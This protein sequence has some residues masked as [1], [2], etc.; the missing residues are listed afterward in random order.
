MNASI[1]A[2]AAAPHPSARVDSI[3]P[4]AGVLTFTFLR[5]DGKP[6]DS[7][8]SIA[9][10]APVDPVEVQTEAGVEITYPEPSVEVLAAAVDALFPPPP[11][12][13]APPT[14]AERK[15]VLKARAAHRR[16]EIETGGFVLDGLPIRTDRESQAMLSGAITFCDLE[17]QAVIRWKLPNGS[18]AELGE[19][20]L[21]GLALAVGRHVQEAFARE[22]E[23]A[24]EI[25]A[26]ATLEELTALA[27]VVEAFVAPPPAPPPP[28]PEP[29]PELGVPEA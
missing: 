27:A 19:T 9:R 15:A 6:A 22:A 4:K 12:P 18:F 20:G 25:E 16:W 13:P 23:L 17:S 2:L 21:R 10:F 3:D 24:A 28:P 11:P 29:G 1:L 5:A 26:S 7:G 14:L 8:G